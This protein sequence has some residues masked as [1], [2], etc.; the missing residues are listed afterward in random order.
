M[1][2]KKGERIMTLENK[3]YKILKEN[4]ISVDSIMEFSNDEYI[5]FDIT[6]K[7]GSNEGFYVVVND[8][9]EQCSLRIHY[10]PDAIRAAA[11]MIELLPNN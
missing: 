2:N 5:Y 4:K 8:G 9:F 1:N 3:V 10:K 7:L 11:S 6:I